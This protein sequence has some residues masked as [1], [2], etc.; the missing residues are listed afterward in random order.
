MNHSKL[1]LLTI[2]EKMLVDFFT[3]LAQFSFTTS[4]SELGYYHQKVNIQAAPR[5]A[6]LLKT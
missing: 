6:E 3:F 2:M 1:N 5:V 4:E